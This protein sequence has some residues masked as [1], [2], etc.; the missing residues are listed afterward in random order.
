MESA[1]CKSRKS[2]K[3]PIFNF[4]AECPRRMAKTLFEVGPH[5]DW[6]QSCDWISMIQLQEEGPQR[7]ERTFRILQTKQQIL[8]LKPSSITNNAFKPSPIEFSQQMHFKSRNKS[9]NSI[10][11]MTLRF[12]R[13]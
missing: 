9:R 2:V 12:V 8:R 10:F 13:A 1:R 3:V 5:N 6:K 7:S 11:V 4:F